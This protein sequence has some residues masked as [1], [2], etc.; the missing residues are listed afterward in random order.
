MQGLTPEQM[1]YLLQF[2]H[3]S[4][5]LAQM[6]GMD[7]ATVAHILNVAIDA[8]RQVRSGFV[9]QAREVAAE[10]LA[11]PAFSDR[12]GRLPFSPGDTVV[13]LGDSITDDWQSWLEIL[14]HLLDLRR[15]QDRIQVINAGISGDTTS[16][17]MSRFLDVVLLKPDWIICMA[18][19]NDA[20]RHGKSPTKVLVSVEETA[21]NLEMLRHF[22]ATQTSA[23]WVWMTP[24]TVIE[25]Q[26]PAHWFLGPMQLAWRNEDLAAIAEVVRRQPDPVVD[27]YALFGL[28][29]NPEW[30]LPD[31]LHP[32][33]AGQKAIVSALVEQL[34]G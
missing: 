23:R 13:A 24:G 10:L 14:R 9:A 6:P 5:I 27:L 30:L 34:S 22:A 33:L 19:T 26:I 3:P 25:E 4:K 7:E 32:S 16:Q 21:K 15:P 28:P 20:R 31:G 11:D 29:A 1:A 12:V 2:Q 8:Y 17:M 18:G